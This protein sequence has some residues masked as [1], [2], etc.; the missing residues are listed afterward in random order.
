MYG[1]NSTE[2]YDNLKFNQEERIR[3]NIIFKEE[4]LKKEP[5]IFN[6]IDQV[7]K[8]LNEKYKLV[9]IS[10][11]YQEEV[12]QKLERYN[13]KKYFDLIIGNKSHTKR[14]EKTEG[15]LKILKELGLNPKE[16]IL[17]C[18]RN[19][20]FIEGTKAGLTTLRLK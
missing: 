11:S 8:T 2:C 14:F 15:I 4:I 19:I 12:E 9:L 18:D 6:G 10:S 1:Q 5:L 17:V 20:D 7:V 13:I 16:V 3:G